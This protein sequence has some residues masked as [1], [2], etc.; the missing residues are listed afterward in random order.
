MPMFLFTSLIAIVFAVMSAGGF[1]T[2][3]EGVEVAALRERMADEDLPPGEVAEI[4]RR[5]VFFESVVKN[6]YRMDTDRIWERR[7]L[8]RRLRRIR[9]H[10]WACFGI[11]FGLFLGVVLR[12]KPVI[13]VVMIAILPASLGSPTGGTVMNFG[14]LLLLFGRFSI[15]RSRAKEREQP[16]ANG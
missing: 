10:A 6:L 4:V 1:W 12:N 3:A 8:A 7:R 9:H 2:V 15:G 11:T 16:D 13:V 14:L 5:S